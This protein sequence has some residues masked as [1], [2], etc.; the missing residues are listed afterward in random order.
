MDSRSLSIFLAIWRYKAGHVKT[1]EN[2]EHLEFGF[3]DIKNA[4]SIGVTDY[5]LILDELYN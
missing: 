3:R 4:D 1:R 5:L 2:G